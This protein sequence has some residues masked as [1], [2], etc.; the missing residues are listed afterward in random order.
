MKKD[1]KGKGGMC[2]CGTCNW[3]QWVLPLVLLA[4]ALVPGWL[5][6]TWG[7]WVV[8]IVAALYIIKRLKPCKACMA[9]CK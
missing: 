6:S 5:T 1:S 9:N 3:V 4:V 7:K 2:E 8:I